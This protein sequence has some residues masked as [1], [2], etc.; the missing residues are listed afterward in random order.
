MCEDTSIG[1]TTN[2]PPFNQ[3]AQRSDGRVVIVF[4]ECSPAKNV[5]LGNTSD[6]IFFRLCVL[7]FTGPSSLHSECRL[8]A[9]AATDTD[10]LTS[11]YRSPR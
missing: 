6:S 5:G 3:A 10:T 8:D 9:H 1:A 7:A 11:G 4:L 2:Q